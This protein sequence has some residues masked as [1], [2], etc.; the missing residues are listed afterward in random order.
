MKYKCIIF[1]C[2][3]VLV[4]SEKIS[5]DVLVEMTRKLGKE[6]NATLLSEQFSGLSLKSIFEKIE[7]I[8]GKKIP[9]DFESI[10]RNETFLRFQSDL[11][12]ILGVKEII[13]DLS[14]PFCVASSGPLK[15]IELN[16]KKTKLFKHFKGNIFSSYEIGSWK[17]E[18]EIFIYAAQKMGFRPNECLVIEDSI[19]GIR[20]AKKGGFNVFGFTN[21]NEQKVFDEENL[22]IF[23]KMSELKLLLSK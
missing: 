4:D 9:E 16:L 8:I 13:E 17:P 3:G 23:Q 22:L 21:Q 15:K 1:D 5:M 11:Q 7:Q 2:D 18:P 20:A 12:P 19:A 6:I 14:I 10:Y